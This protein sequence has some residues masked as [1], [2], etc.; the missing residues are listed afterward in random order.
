[1]AAIFKRNS[2]W[3]LAES[4]V[5]R[6][7]QFLHARNAVFGEWMRSEELGRPAGLLE[8]LQFLKESDHSLGIV[9]RVKGV[10]KAP[11]VR[12]VLV[13]AAKFHEDDVPENRAGIL[14]DAASPDGQHV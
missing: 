3:S 13:V 14:D 7:D 12:I 8:G 5:L 2:S 10:G 9:A 6:F 1:M 4:I 11:A